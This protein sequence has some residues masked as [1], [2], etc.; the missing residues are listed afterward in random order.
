MVFNQLSGNRIFLEN[1]GIYGKTKKQ[2]PKTKTKQDKN[3]CPLDWTEV[4]GREGFCWP[5][6]TQSY[7]HTLSLSEVSSPSCLL[8]LM[9]PFWLPGQ[10]LHQTLVEIKT[11]CQCKRHLEPRGLNL[12]P[13]DPRPWGKAGLSRPWPGRSLHTYEREAGSCGRRLRAAQ[14][15]SLLLRTLAVQGSLLGMVPGAAG[16][17][18]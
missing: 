1:S 6:P 17:G 2:K 5:S 15:P 11:P 9:W 3:P 10:D 13:G 4:W 18:F 12:S 7:A 14:H 8:W 16:E